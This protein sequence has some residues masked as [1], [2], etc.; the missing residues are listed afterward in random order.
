MLYHQLDSQTIFLQHTIPREEQVL[1]LQAE[2]L[3]ITGSI[4]FL[5]QHIANLKA[6]GKYRP[7][8]TDTS[9]F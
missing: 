8:I 3:Q 1:F 5:M 2:N 7:H 9:I 6:S 4:N